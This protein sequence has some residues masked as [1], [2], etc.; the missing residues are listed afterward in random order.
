MPTLSIFQ[1]Y[2]GKKGTGRGISY[3]G[4]YYLSTYE[5]WPGNRDGFWLEGSYKRENTVASIIHW[6][7]LVTL[8]AK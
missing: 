8:N 3:D 4:L 5:I 6:K 1:L 2:R 7:I